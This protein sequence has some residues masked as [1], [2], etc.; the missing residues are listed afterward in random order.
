MAASAYSYFGVVCSHESLTNIYCS[1]FTY[2]LPSVGAIY[3]L[4]M[5]IS[6]CERGF[7]LETLPTY[8]DASQL[9]AIYL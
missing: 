6:K 3:C 1:T 5:Q 7:I 2:R 8:I 9:G 4:V